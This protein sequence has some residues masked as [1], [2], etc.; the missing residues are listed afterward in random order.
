M[1]E[2]AIVIGNGTVQR[3]V[4]VED[5]IDTVESIWKAYGEEKIIMPPKITTDMS[6]AGVD[7]WFNSMPCYIQ[8]TDT[9]GIKVVGGYNG[10]KALGLPFI[11]ANVLLTDS[12]TGLL[13]ALVA[14]DWIS[15]MRTGAQPAIM[16]EALASSTDVVTII[17]AGLQGYTS[18]LC[19][20]KRLKMKEVRIC[21]LS[22]E[23]KKSFIEKFKDAD[24]EIKDY[25]DVEKACKDSDIIITVTTANA[26]LVK[27]AWVKKGALVMTMGSF[28]E[29]EFDVVRNADIIAVDHPE[30]ALHR[31]NLKELAEAGEITLESIDATLPN[32]LAGK[33]KG[34]K[35][36]D[37]R[38]YAEIV[39]M[40]CPDVAIAALAYERII[41][42]GEELV[43]VDMT[44]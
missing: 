6:S 1:K 17:G 27:D 5:V 36:P 4:S 30:Q 14:G 19:M 41:N 15:D 25:E 2:T 16:A 8:D 26:D 39:G 29:T 33:Q 11:K 28:R 38:I 20:S 23:A 37:D 18:L 12:R 32:I 21:D 42:S 44:K 9:A 40:G 35:S 22:K 10:N 3:F 7:G 13:K 34:R 31:G 24:F 43:E